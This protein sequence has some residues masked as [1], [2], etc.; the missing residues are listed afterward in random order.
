MIFPPLPPAKIL[1]PT[2]VDGVKIEHV[3]YTK[4]DMVKAM[5]EAVELN[6]R[7]ARRK[8]LDS[9]LPEASRQ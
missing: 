6:E 8:T 9:K 4:E 5:R 1:S 7:E 2:F 3:G